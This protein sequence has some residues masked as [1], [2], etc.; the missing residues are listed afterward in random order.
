[1]PAREGAH[2]AKNPRPSYPSLARKQG[3][4]GRVLLKV[5]VLPSGRADSVQVQTSS[6]RSTLDEAAVAAVKNWTF[7]PAKQGGAPLAGWVTVPIDFRLE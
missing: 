2:Y 4:Q 6:G 7:E 5:H 1:V 3:W